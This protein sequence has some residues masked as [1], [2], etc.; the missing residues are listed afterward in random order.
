MK[1]RSR[2]GTEIHRRGQGPAVR[3]ACRLALGV[4]AALGTVA[5][6][7]SPERSITLEPWPEA[8]AL[9]HRDANWLGGDDAGSIDLGDGRVAWFFGDSFVAPKSPGERRGSTMVH[10]SVGLQTGYDPMHARFRTFW[11]DDGGKPASFFADQG[12]DYL[13]PG[14]SRIIDGKLVVFFMR[15]RTA[16][17]P[18]GFESRGWGAALIDNPAES[19][20]RWH[21]RMLA[22]PPNPWDVFVGSSSVLLEGR[23]VIACSVANESHDVFLVSWPAEAV[24][25]GDVSRPEWW[26]GVQRG[27][28]AQSD[29]AELPP[30]LLRSGQ[31]EFTL[32]RTPNNA[33]YLQLQFASF[34]KS[35]IAYRTAP[36]IVGPWTE[37]APAYS[38][39]EAKSPDKRLTCYA[40]KAHPELRGPG[41]VVTYCTNTFDFAQLID[42][43][44]IYY[45]RFLT[46]RWTDGSRERPVAAERS[47]GVPL[48]IQGRAR[49]K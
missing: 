18:L 3:R 27:W 34:P 43:S 19:P 30:P 40:A 32:H 37:L 17:S 33:A 7:A 2:C 31:T 36:A 41:L 6:A 4:C 26:S 11:R 5:G 16:K 15:V 35:P 48:P 9:F 8:D 46:L 13:W 38:P 23:R 21:V 20:S 49:N 10:N 47:G 14:G 39:A 25:E 1:A 45:P 28:V 29:L 24:A 44:A 22:A 12:N 42:D